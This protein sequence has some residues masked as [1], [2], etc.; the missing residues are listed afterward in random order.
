MLSVVR[1]L[2]L[3]TSYHHPIISPLVECMMDYLH[4]GYLSALYTKKKTFSNTIP[5]ISVHSLGNNITFSKCMI[6]LEHV[7]SH[8]V[9]GEIANYRSKKF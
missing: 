3:S 4:A 5:K 8:G 1:N 2:C 6:Y 9:Q 7:L